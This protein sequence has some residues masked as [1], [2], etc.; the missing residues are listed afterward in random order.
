[1]KELSMRALEWLW[2]AIL[3]LTRV[4]TRRYRNWYHATYQPEQELTLE[5]KQLTNQE[6]KSLGGY[7]HW[8]AAMNMLTGMLLI[9]S[10]AVVIVGVIQ[11]IE[12]PEMWYFCLTFTFLPAFMLFGQLV[13][14]PYNAHQCLR[15]ITPLIWDHPDVL[16][17]RKQRKYFYITESGKIV[18]T[19]VKPFFLL[20]S[21]VRQ[22]ADVDWGAYKNNRIRAALDWAIM[23]TLYLRFI[24]PFILS[25]MQLAPLAYKTA[26]RRVEFRQGQNVLM[27]GAGP[28]PYHVWWKGRLGVDGHIVALD[29]DPYVNH[30]S[31]QVE[32]VYEWVRGLLLER[33]W[34]SA[35]VTG[36]AE[37][38]PF[39][40]D[41]FDIVVAIRCYH[42]NVGEALRTLKPGG[43]LLIDDNSQVAELDRETQQVDESTSWW[44][45]TA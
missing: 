45:V 16:D 8:T 44:I 4:I 22:R 34:V 37:E 27:I 15:R 39:A 20:C 32:R 3:R 13:I 41:S 29:I 33:R 9:V 14:R 40:N 2:K 24:W 28:L 6:I 1:M 7:I 35:H 11:T 12:K 43:K 25:P 30:T 31:F 18:F 17:A 38:L 23:S 5:L 26:M 42:V 21:D 19:D 10:I 36:D